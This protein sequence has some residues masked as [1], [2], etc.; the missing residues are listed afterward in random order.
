MKLS[1]INPTYTIPL[2]RLNEPAYLCRFAR[3]KNLKDYAYV[4][5]IIDP[6]YNVI[7]L[8]IGRSAS[9]FLGERIY[10]QAAWLPGWN[11]PEPFSSAGSD[12]NNIK[13][14]LIEENSSFE[15]NN[16]TK[17]NFVIKV[18]DVTGYP[19]DSQDAARN[20]RLAENLLLDEYESVHDCLPIGN[21]KD[22]RNE[23]IGYEVKNSLWDSI[24][25]FT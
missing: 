3:S 12:I 21:Q 1:L 25:E 2:I 24:I 4:F 9:K 7:N 23:M 19:N 20:S 11:Q 10:R 5:E 15:C 17:N 13:E 8:K 6:S 14:L 22:T 16:W 18:W